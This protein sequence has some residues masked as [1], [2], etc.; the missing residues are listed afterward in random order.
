MSNVRNTT[1]SQATTEQS[2]RTHI[3]R[4][5]STLSERA[6]SRLA[7]D[8]QSFK[9][10]ATEVAETQKARGADKIGGVADAVHGAASDLEQHMPRAAGYVHQAA[11]TIDQASIALKQLNT[12]D[13]V[14]G[15]EQFARSQPAVLFAASVL[16]GFALSRFLKSSATPSQFDTAGGSR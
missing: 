2:R 12:G 8:V 5:A 4:Q 11:D 7:E 15:F 3:E 16:A 1:E 10:K 13:L 6:S 14:R 9:D